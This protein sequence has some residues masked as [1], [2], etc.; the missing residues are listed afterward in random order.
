MQI[1][2]AINAGTLPV[3]HEQTLNDAQK[4]PSGGRILD[5]FGRDNI[6]LDQDSNY[7]MLN[8]GVSLFAE[9]Y[10]VNIAEIWP[11]TALWGLWINIS[12]PQQSGVSGLAKRTFMCLLTSLFI[13]TGRGNL[14]AD[15]KFSRWISSAS[16]PR[17]FPWLHHRPDCKEIC[18]QRKHDTRMWKTSKEE[19]DNSF[20]LLKKRIFR[21]THG[22][23]IDGFSMQ[24]VL[25]MHELFFHRRIYQMGLILEV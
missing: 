8:I 13:K 24:C 18:P 1:A 9:P 20:S 16:A 2:A 15:E 6:F 21:D 7:F 10:S 11:V 5:S 25:C 4:T 17:T 23:F 3:T 14:W 12:V 22:L 19:A